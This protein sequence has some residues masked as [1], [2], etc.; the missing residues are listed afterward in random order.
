MGDDHAKASGSIHDPS[1]RCPVCGAEQKIPAPNEGCE[2]RR[3][4]ADLEAWLQTR[5]SIA[6]QA[7]ETIAAEIKKVSGHE[8][9]GH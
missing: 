7:I 6:L 2:C 5:R 8:W 4:R 3:C 9:H 1:I